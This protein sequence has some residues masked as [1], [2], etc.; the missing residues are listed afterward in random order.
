[1]KYDAALTRALHL[2]KKRK[3][4]D[5]ADELEKEVVGYQDSWLYCYVLAVA[6]TRLKDYGKA[7]TWFTSAWNKNKDEWK[8]KAALAALYLR[9]GDR[10]RAVQFYLDIQRTEK[11]NKIAAHGLKVI[12]KYREPERL[13][14]WTESRRFLRLVPPLPNP[15]VSLGQVL[16]GSGIAA[17]VLAICYTAAVFLG[18]LPSPIKKTPQREGLADSALA[19]EEKTKPL[20]TGGQYSLILTQGELLAAY[21]TARGYF[22]ARRDEKARVEINRILLSNASEPVKNTARILQA[23]L[24]EPDWGSLKDRFTIKEVL[25]SPLLYE[26]CYVI[27]GGRTADIVTGNESTSFRLLVGYQDMR[28]IEG[29]V[30]VT[31][32]FSADING[33]APIEILG[34]IKSDGAKIA[35][36][37]VAVHQ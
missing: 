12:K 22:N 31:L 8:N 1:M 15:G 36:A 28:T 6:Y 17:I 21:E 37:G 13:A 3:A 32:G 2:L 16:V 20:E 9:R 25:T 23:F 4:A 33:E 35:L 24:A 10:K 29:D 30:T 26:G 5:A 34:R 18:C 7:F 27:W 14:A 19:L 11:G